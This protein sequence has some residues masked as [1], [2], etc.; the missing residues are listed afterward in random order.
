[1]KRKEVNV[2]INRKRKRKRKGFTLIEVI[3][4]IAILGILGF[5]LV[6]KVAGYQVKAQKSNY[7]SS[8]KVMINAIKAYNADATTAIIDTDLVGGATN[9]M[10]KVNTP[11][12]VIST[13]DAT[14]VKMV[15][16][17]LTVAQLAGIANGNFTL[18]STSSAI[19]ATTITDGKIE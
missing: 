18:N 16:A 4:V 2:I 1:M 9:A 7:Q 11:T 6:P 14:Y 12:V 13:T 15:T 3:A 5:I 10:S 19:D 8:A 17:D